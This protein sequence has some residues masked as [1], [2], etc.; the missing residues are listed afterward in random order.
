[1]VRVTKILTII[2]VCIF[3]LSVLGAAEGSAQTL[4][5]EAV[6]APNADTP[7]AAKPLSSARDPLEITAQQNLEW[8]RDDK[9]LIARGAARAVRGD[10]A[11]EADQ[12]SATY[13]ENKS[14]GGMKISKI[15]AEENVVLTARDSKAYGGRAQYDMDAGYAEMTGEGL[16]VVTPQQTITAQEKFTYFVNEGRVE[17]IGRAKLIRPQ[18][19][20]EADVL[21][22]IFKDDSGGSRKIETAEAKGNVVIT[23]PD[24]TATGGYGIYRASTGKAELTGGVKI[25]R[26]PNTLT[27]DRAE[28]DMNTN[29][30]RIFAAPAR[31]NN[32]GPGRVRA[33]F[34]P[35]AKGEQ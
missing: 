15:L 33:I 14:G 24:E 2:S 19:S 7:A 21:S 8:R 6:F 5:G 22:A 23:T 11:I 30:S 13:S 1:M 28:I 10:L 9:M 4:T 26:G 3:A 20:I 27:G 18:N 17:A 32:S 12:L 31:D 25:T 16:K 29:I 35:E 34:Y